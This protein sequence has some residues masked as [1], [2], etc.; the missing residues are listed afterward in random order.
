MWINRNSE[1]SSYNNNVPRS[2][3][4]ED[5]DFEK[6]G[7]YKDVEKVKKVRRMVASNS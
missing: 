7:D 6:D 2:L 3:L 4:G 5:D 1:D